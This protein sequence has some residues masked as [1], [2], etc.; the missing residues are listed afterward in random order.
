MQ[1]RSL[2]TAVAMTALLLLLPGVV[3]AGDS[4]GLITANRTFVPTEQE[5]R[6]LQSLP[7][8]KIMVD[9]A[10]VP[11]SYYNA[12]THSYEGVSVDLFRHIAKRLGLKYQ[13]LRD[14]K[15][16]WADKIALFNNHKIDLLMSAS[17]T[18]E[19]SKYGLFTNSFYDSFYGAVAKK[20]RYLTL[21]N[22][23][24]LA[25]F[26]VG[27]TKATS[28][29]QFIKTFVPASQIVYY[30]NP[31]E[32]YRGIRDGQVDVG[33]RN[34]YVFQEERFNM[35]LFDLFMIHTIDESP[36]KYCYYFI[37]SDSN[38]KLI[39]IINRYL[40]GV[41][42]G[43]LIAHYEKGEDELVLRYIHQVQEKKLLGL[44]TA[45]AA[46]SMLLACTAW[47]YYRKLSRKLAETN[48]KLESLIVTD[49]LTGLGNRRHFDEVLSKEYARHERTG[50]EL[51]L[52]MLDLDQFKPFNDNYGHI[53][54]DECLQ[55]VA[56]VIG[57]CACR[58]AD[59][60]VR[61]GGEEFACI[62]P[63][64]DLSG[65][66]AIAEKIRQGVLALAIPH[67][68]SNVA[69]VVTTSLG[70]ATVK[71]DSN[72]SSADLLAHADEFLYRAKSYGRNRVEFS[73][74]VPDCHSVPFPS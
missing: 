60:A 56:T 13:F 38:R 45:G 15:L 42:Y 39:G 50:S 64:T 37:K 61:Y 7:S 48:L 44:V 5:A 41:D 57:E 62:L 29:L 3:R 52:I 1:I 40:A 47:L 32:L 9:E 27:V 18:E 73:S 19:R 59:L 12:K 10:F 68:G 26:K 54:G 58:A 66:V 36:C 55:Q 74:L 16:S 23:Y 30:N 6:F 65:A 53:R 51:S 17:V 33:L 21:K 25:H 8:I 72:E 24:D 34:K 31:A 49:A 28:I 14:E 43:K 69:E 35:E 11:L 46:V 70:V 67:K 71:C 4:D 22:S 2:L 20:S 63:E